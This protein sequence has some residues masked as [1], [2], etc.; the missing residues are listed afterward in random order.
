M[1]KRVPTFVTKRALVILAKLRS[2][3]DWR[4]FQGKR[5]RRDRS[6]V[7][8]PIGMRW[9]LVVQI[10]DMGIHALSISSHADYNN[11]IARMR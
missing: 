1:K 4:V 10:T 3:I 11:I 9:R 7:S 5:L 6:I 2:G 8:I